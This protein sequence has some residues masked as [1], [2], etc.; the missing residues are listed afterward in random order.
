MTLVIVKVLFA[1]VFCGPVFCQRSLCLC[2]SWHLR[3]FEPFPVELWSLHYPAQES[4]DY[5][6]AT[7]ILCFYYLS[8]IKRHFFYSEHQVLNSSLCTKLIKSLKGWV[9][10]RVFLVWN[11]TL[12]W[13]DFKVLCVCVFTAPCPEPGAEEGCCRRAGQLYCSKSKDTK[14]I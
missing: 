4:A 3:E 10:N 2:V 1:S 12:W 7:H 13:V 14:K 8:I 9:T 11:L 5:E 6:T